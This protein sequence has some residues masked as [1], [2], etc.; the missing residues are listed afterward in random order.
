MLAITVGGSPVSS[1][2]QADALSLKRGIF[3]G[4]SQSESY[5]NTTI[6]KQQELEDELNASSAEQPSRPWWSSSKRDKFRWRRFG[7]RYATPLTLEQVLA[8]ETPGTNQSS[9]QSKENDAPA[10]QSHPRNT[11]KPQEV[12]VS[13][14]LKKE[15]SQGAVGGQESARNLAEF[16]K[17]KATAG[18]GGADENKPLKLSPKQA[19]AKLSPK[20][21]GAQ[22]SKR[23]YAEMMQKKGLMSKY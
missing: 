5:D 2:G 12:Q 21:A 4:L 6:R 7:V 17:E 23:L 13:R 20:Q 19:G 15:R 9:K 16:K 1:F 11:R 8:L 18:K 22:E 3:S 14:S 10:G